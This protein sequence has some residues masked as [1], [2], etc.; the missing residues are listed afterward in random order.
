MA[1]QQSS[2]S[3]PGKT[4]VWQQFNQTPSNPFAGENPVT[5]VVNMELNPDKSVRTRSGFRTIAN[6]GLEEPDS[7]ISTYLVESDTPTS[8]VVAGNGGLYEYNFGGKTDSF[9]ARTL[10]TTPVLNWASLTAGEPGYFSSYGGEVYFCQSVSDSHALLAYDGTTFRNLGVPGMAGSYDGNAPEVRSGQDFD[11]GD[12][13]FCGYYVECCD[14]DAG[15]ITNCER[16]PDPFAPGSTGTAIMFCCAGWGDGVCG[17]PSLCEGGAS[18]GNCGNPAGSCDDGDLVRI[19][20]CLA[21]AGLGAGF[22]WHV[23]E[24]AYSGRGEKILNFSFKIGY[25]DPKRGI[26]GRAYDSYSVIRFGPNR[27]QYPIWQYQSVIDSPDVD[28]VGI[29]DYYSVAVWCSIGQEVLTIKTPH[30]NM[31]FMLHGE[32]H[33]MS[34]HFN[35]TMYLEIIPVRD[36]NNLTQPLKVGIAGDACPAAS[37]CIYKDQTSLVDSGKYTEQYDRP[38]PSKGMVV[39]PSGTALYLFPQRIL[40]LDPIAMGKHKTAWAGTAYESLAGDYRP[41]VEYSVGHP[42]QIGRWT[43]KQNETFASLPSLRGEP[44]FATNDGG[45]AILLTRQT[46]Y[47][48][49]YGNGSVQIQEMGGPG[50]LDHQSVH[51]NSNGLMFV[52]DE[53]PVWVRGGRAVEILRELKFDGWMDKLSEADKKEVRI[54]MMED[55]KKLLMVFPTYGIDGGKRYR[56]LMHDVSNSFTSEWWI[57]DGQV[58]APELTDVGSSD[59][60][61]SMIS[62]KHEDGY[63]FFMWLN[64]NNAGVTVNTISYDESLTANGK[65]NAELTDVGLSSIP[66][67]LEMWVNQVPHLDKQAGVFTVDFSHRDGDITIRASSFESPTDRDDSTERPLEERTAT[68]ID[69]DPNLN[70]LPTFMGMRGKYIRIR[71]ETTGHMGVKRATLD[72]NFDMTPQIRMSPIKGQ[73][74]INLND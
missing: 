55:T 38:V 39:L 56:T 46:M 50:I 23:P 41:G 69:S 65:N 13:N 34:D 15:E 7:S 25:Y 29:P 35:D 31:P 72:V 18:G 36:G 2:E 20:Q 11:I 43:D 22:C 51:S 26:F 60:V 12:G 33:A 44:V 17:A 63:D 24:V 32:K 48:L 58:A 70:V 14:E 59:S 71:I 53:G 49:G 61:S 54:G 8:L 5:R 74:S 73:H 40:S 28:S 62:H 47:Q 45:A 42:E 1:E 19:Y 4:V 30:P 9:V 16:R 37:L 3:K 68:I 52:G 27:D 10:P 64:R 21:Q 6:N 57:G 66:S 67:I